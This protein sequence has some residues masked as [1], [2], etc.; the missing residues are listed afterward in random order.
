MIS[1]DVQDKVKERE[2]I[3]HLT[4]HTLGQ[5][6]LKLS[7]SLS[8]VRLKCC[9]HTAPVPV[10]WDFQR[11]GQGEPNQRKLRWRAALSTWS[12][13]DDGNVLSNR[14]ATS[15]IELEHVKCG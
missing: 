1:G 8:W 2:S 10:L 6:N 15:H 7:P 3:R 11:S 4:S 13:C 14:Q 12:F 9:V 5:E